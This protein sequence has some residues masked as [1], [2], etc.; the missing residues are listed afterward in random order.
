MAKPVESGP[1]CRRLRSIAVISPPTLAAPSRW[2]RP[3]IPHMMQCSFS[4][5]I[6]SRQSAVGYPLPRLTTADCRLPCS[7]RLPIADCRSWQTIQVHLQVPLRRR[8]E[9]ALPFVALVLVVEAVHLAGQRRADDLVVLQRFQ[10]VAEGHRQLFDL[11][12]GF[13]GLVD[14]AL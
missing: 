10:R 5:P 7:C 13:H 1:R 9:E 6:G 8:V 2:I 12:A 3:A 4:A 14:V 11:L